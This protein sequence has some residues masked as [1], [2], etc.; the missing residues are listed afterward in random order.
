MHS[1]RILY[2]EDEAYLAS[3]VI[4]LLKKADIAVDWVASGEEG[5][6]LATKPGYD[7][8]VLDI[9]LPSVSGWDI[10]KEVRSQGL[11]T[12][13]LMLSALAEVDDKVRALEAGADDY[14]AKPFKT[15]E[16]IARLKALTRRPPLQTDETLRYADLEYDLSNRL[17]NGTPL[18]AKEAEL[19][20]LLI[21]HPEQ[22]QPKA[23]LLA[24]AWGNEAASSDNYVEVYM[25]YLRKKLEQLG[26]SA[27]I[28][29]IRNLGYKLTSEK[30]VS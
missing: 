22:I 3:A 26:S 27:T 21:R 8:L 14:L 15:A 11:T 18:T 25:S 23:Q 12:P 20:E 7:C 19:F 6:K 28:K 30:D 10:L 5:L 9:M 29:T 4:H 16:L 24:R 13:I 1:M 17:L 2:V